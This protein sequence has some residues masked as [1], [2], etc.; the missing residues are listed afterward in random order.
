MSEEL[1]TKICA[2]LI[3]QLSL[4]EGRQCER[5]VLRYSQQ[6]FRDEDLRSWAR[7]DDPEIFGSLITIEEVTSTIIESAEAH[8]YALDQGSHRYSVSTRQ[9]LGGRA[10]LHFT[11]GRPHSE[12]SHP[13]DLD[14][15]LRLVRQ[16]AFAEADRPK[17]PS[18]IPAQDEGEKVLEAA[19]LVDELVAKPRATA[20]LATQ[21]ESANVKST[22][23]YIA[24]GRKP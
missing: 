22:E 4:T 5:I 20:L 18:E 13:G 7:D 19:R 6:G 15:A 23:R 9:Y 12:T 3:Q 21:K 8:A 11:M 14:A 2:F 24:I 1:H 10:I 16:I 17:A